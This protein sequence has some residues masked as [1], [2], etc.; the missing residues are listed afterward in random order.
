MNQKKAKALRRLARD[1]SVGLPQAA[2]QGEEPRRFR[3][4]NGQTRVYYP[5]PGIAHTRK[6]E[7]ASTRAVYRELKAK[8]L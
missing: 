8:Q 7:P 1:C 3:M 2:Y 5:E 4:R 6:L